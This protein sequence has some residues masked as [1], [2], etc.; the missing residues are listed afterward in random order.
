MLTP[1]MRGHT[2]HALHQQKMQQHALLYPGEPTR[3]TA[4]KVFIGGWLCRHCLLRIYQNSKLPEGK[5]VFNT[6]Y[7]VLHSGHNKPSFSVREWW[8][9][10]WNSNSQP[11]KQAF[12]KIEVWYLLYWCSLHKKTFTI[13]FIYKKIKNLNSE[14]KEN[15]SK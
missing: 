15:I 7:I 13:I 14:S 3:D 2:E 4:S 11:G 12:L 1:P 9:N 6:N 10:P 8:V 5:R